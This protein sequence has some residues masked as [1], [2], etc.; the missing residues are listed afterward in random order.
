MAQIVLKS[1]SENLHKIFSAM[2]F[3]KSWF[4]DIIG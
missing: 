1:F 4:Y 3:T 2:S